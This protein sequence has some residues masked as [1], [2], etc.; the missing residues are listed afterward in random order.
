MDK[1]D[2]LFI[3]NKQIHNCSKC[4][5]LRKVTPNSMPIWINYE[6]IDKVKYLIIGLNPGLEGIQ[7]EYEQ[8]IEDQN[9][10][11]ER[12]LNTFLT[13]TKIG[14]FINHLINKANMDIEEFA[15]TNIIKCR[16]PKDYN[17]RNFHYEN[18][19]YFLELQIK[20][21]EPKC[22]IIL[23]KSF[24]KYISIKSKLDY[25]ILNHPSY[26]N[27]DL[28]RIEFMQDFEYFK[29]K[30]EK[31]IQKPNFS[32]NVIVNDDDEYLF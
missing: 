12:Y 16:K 23:G 20:I 3:L 4:V 28:N 31:I 24:S 21:L 30:M 18:C 2:V 26:Y 17:L 25:I 29:D 10:F 27:Y 15:F 9:I 11:Y 8:Q 7:N 14:K 13:Y 22:L 19:Y 32:N 1:K 6:K 5:E